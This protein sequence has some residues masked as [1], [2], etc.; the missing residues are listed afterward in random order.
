MKRIF[1]LFALA[2]ALPM[3][4]FASSS[5]DFT[6]SGGTLTATTTNCSGTCLAVS[7]STLV[8]VNGLNGLGLVTGNNLGTLSFE[9]G[10]LTSGSLAGQV[11]TPSLFAAGGSFVISSNGANGLP[12][13]TLFTGSFSGPVSWQLQQL[14]NGQDIYQLSGVISGTWYTGQTVSGATVQ[15]T[16]AT[17]KNGFQ[18]SITL[19]SGDTV[20]SPVTEPSTLGLL[21]TGLVGLAGLLK[22]RIKA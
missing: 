20:I 22:R 18:G 8:A 4:V 15:L 2:L 11:G 16:I 19:G 5:I 17:G 13:A 21:G 6:N 12:N 3:A 14:A 10:A 1:L 9:T 7:S